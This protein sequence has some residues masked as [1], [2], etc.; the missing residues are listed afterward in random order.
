MVYFGILLMV[1]IR[2]LEWVGD[3]CAT[4]LSEGKK[5]VCMGPPKKEKKVVRGNLVQVIRLERR[6]NAGEEGKKRWGGVKP[7]EMER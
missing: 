3:E 2:V 7:G 1:S 4:S 6:F 5:E